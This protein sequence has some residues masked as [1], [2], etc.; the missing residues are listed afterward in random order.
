M[1]D[2]IIKEFDKT[3][4]KWLEGKEHKYSCMAYS[5]GQFCCLDEEEGALSG[6]K[7]R[8]WVKSFLIKAL[9]AQK[10]EIKEMIES[11]RGI[12]D[13]RITEFVKSVILAGLREL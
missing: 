7:G 3:L 10:Q 4:D 11:V 9:S 12:D 6:G 8:I 1:D 5:E 2:K 13:D